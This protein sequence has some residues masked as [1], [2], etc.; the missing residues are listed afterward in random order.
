MS[1]L[2]RTLRRKAKKIR[3]TLDELLFGPLPPPNIE[4]LGER[5][6]LLNEFRECMKFMNAPNAPAALGVLQRHYDTW[7]HQ[8]TSRWMTMLDNILALRE[9]E[10][11]DRC[12]TATGGTGDG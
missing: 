2:Q 5:Q 1:S 4:A 12:G 8:Q 10:R 9:V 7:D 11:E 3:I 6:R